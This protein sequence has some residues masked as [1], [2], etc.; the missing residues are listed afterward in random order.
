MKNQFIEESSSISSVFCVVQVQVL[1]M[2][3]EIQ[4]DMKSDRTA[5]ISILAE[6]KTS[7]KLNFSLSKSRIFK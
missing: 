5:A 6:E 2:D 3:F 7:L 1:K 4:I